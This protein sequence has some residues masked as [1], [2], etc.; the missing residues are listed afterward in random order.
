MS[1]I[2][3]ALQK[4]NRNSEHRWRRGGGGGLERIA[5]DRANGSE[6]RAGFL[7]TVKGL[8]LRV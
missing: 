6:H 4:R 1:R 8:G 3:V 7:F 5:F 2:Q